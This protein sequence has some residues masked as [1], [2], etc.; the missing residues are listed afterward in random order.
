M[1]AAVFTTLGFNYILSASFKNASQ[2]PTFYLGLY[3]GNYQPVEGDTMASLLSNTTEVTAYEGTTRLALVLGTPANAGVDNQG[4]IAEFVGTG[5][6]T[7][8]G[9]F[10]ATAAGKGA[11]TGLLVGAM[12]F[13]SPELLK[14][15]SKLQLPT[16]FI[17]ANA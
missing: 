8:N 17:F 7:V 4:N 3:T 16:G 9:A 12:L 6:V 14:T 13:P 1:S 15:G 2:Y 11:T 10:V 5:N